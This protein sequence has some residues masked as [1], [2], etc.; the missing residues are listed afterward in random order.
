MSK[1]PSKKI[2]VDL[3]KTLH[4]LDDGHKVNG[5]IQFLSFDENGAGHDLHTTPEVG[6]SC[7]VGLAKYG[8]YRWMTSEITEVISD[9]KFKTKNSEYEIL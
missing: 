2:N 4:R 3:S 6:R 7:V 8:M 9:V 1:L 5:R